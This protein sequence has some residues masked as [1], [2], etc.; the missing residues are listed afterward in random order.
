[1]RGVCWGGWPGGNRGGGQGGGEG[2]HL[3]PGSRCIYWRLITTQQSHH[4]LDDFIIW[5]LGVGRV[6][7]GRSGTKARGRCRTQEHAQCARRGFD[8]GFW[9]VCAGDISE[10]RTWPRYWKAS[11]RL[12]HFSITYIYYF[13]HHNNAVPAC[14]LLPLWKMGLGLFLRIIAINLWMQNVSTLGFNN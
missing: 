5:F 3:I 14:V 7:G 12:F 10:N 8:L 11:T 9:M 6:V 4:A 1:M 2:T 13:H